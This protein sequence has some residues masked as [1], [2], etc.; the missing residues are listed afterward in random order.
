MTH[1]SASRHR[2]VRAALPVVAVAA[3]LGSIAA[4][5]STGAPRRIVSVIPAVTETL[6]ALGAG[7]QIV[8]IGSFDV[9][10]ERHRDAAI[11]RVGGLLDPDT[12]RMLTLR[13][14][15]VILYDS[16]VDPR[17]QLERAGIPVVTYRHGTLMDVLGMVRALGR[18]VGRRSAGELLAARIEA[19][20]AAIR[21]RTHGR[22][23]PRTLL[24]FAREP[25][26]LRGVYAAGGVGFLHDML[27]TAGG[28]NVFTAIR[29]ENVA[30]VSTEAILAAAPEVVIEICNRGAFE[31]AALAAE[32]AV[33]DGLPTLPAVRTGRVHFLH[34]GEFVIPGP[35][36]LEAVESFA[37]LLHLSLI[38][39]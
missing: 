6:F 26:S 34:G 33:W 17:A 20:L 23:R 35:R 27:V 37:R 11:A 39:I 10:P 8:G 16:Q 7:S 31:R 29:G 25:V 28:E 13:P 30:Q 21:A 24:V 3:L 36:V 14:D 38:H 5:Q 4:A 19:G 12:E 15:L 32:R 18:R 2:T 22:R 1:S 9:L